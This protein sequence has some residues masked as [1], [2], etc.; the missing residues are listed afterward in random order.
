MD[1]NYDCERTLSTIRQLLASEFSIA[2]ATLQHEP[3][4]GDSP[5]KNCVE[6]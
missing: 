2:H 3:K 5:E 1:K 6:H 4:M